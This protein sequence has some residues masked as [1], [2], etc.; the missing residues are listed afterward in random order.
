AE[1]RLGNVV[2]THD[3]EI[4]GNLQAG[5]LG[6]LDR[7]DRGEI[8]GG[9]DGG[10]PVLDGE[11]LTGRFL[12]RFGVVAADPD[13]VGVEVDAGSRQGSAIPLLAQTGGFEVGATGQKTDATVSQTDQV[14]GGG[15]GAFEVLGVDGGQVRRA[16][17]GV[18]GHDRN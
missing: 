4:L 14:L 12:G 15:G 9:E 5:C 3:R 2:E 16:G 17:M 10:G 1:S 11:E 7:G 6:D 18:D 8:V 13:Q